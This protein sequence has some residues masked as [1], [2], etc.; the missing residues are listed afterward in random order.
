MTVKSKDSKT[1]TGDMTVGALVSERRHVR[2]LPETG[3]E[4]ALSAMGQKGKRVA[5]V[6][7]ASG[8][9]LGIVTRAGLLGQLVVDQ[10]LKTGHHGKP[11]AECGLSV[12][13]AMI[14]NPAFLPSE[15]G[16]ADALA[17]MG[18]YGAQAMPVL[19]EGG[20]LVG[21]ADMRDLARAQK[22]PKEAGED[23]ESGAGFLANLIYRDAIDQNTPPRP[24]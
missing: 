11:A 7:D 5:G 22:P 8:K 18:E 14:C 4:A 17:I 16:I 20:K 13:D 2:F 19:S 6:I 23:N 10:S 24:K 1:S 12:A 21:I 3:I 15:L 9:C